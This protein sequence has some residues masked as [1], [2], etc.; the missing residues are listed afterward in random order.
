M[1]IFILNNLKVKDSGFSICQQ[2]D[3]GSSLHFCLTLLE[4]GI[5]L[6]L[7][8]YKEINQWSGF[9]NA[10]LQGSIEANSYTKAQLIL[11]R[12]QWGQKLCK[13]ANILFWL[14]PKS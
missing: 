7:L 10:F 4:L 13:R 12:S 8:T 3:F 5:K 6:F 1:G 9:F 11:V 14:V 2:P